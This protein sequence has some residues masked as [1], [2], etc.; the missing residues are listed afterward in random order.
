MNPICTVYARC[1]YTR[2]VFKQTKS[3]LYYYV[4]LAH[5]RHWTRIQPADLFDYIT[6]VD[7][8]ETSTWVF[9]DGE[10]LFIE[11]LPVAHEGKKE[12]T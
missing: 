1:G 6:S 11:G 7:D 8:L 5:D 2:L 9:C 12:R 3:G 4:K 10:W